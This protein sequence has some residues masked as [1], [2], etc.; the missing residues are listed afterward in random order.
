MVL[1]NAMQHQISPNYNGVSNA[2]AMGTTSSIGLRSAREALKLERTGTIMVETSNP[3][4][5]GDDTN[6]ASTIKKPDENIARMKIGRCLATV[7]VVA[8]TL[9]CVKDALVNVP[10]VAEQVV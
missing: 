6:V 7:N 1:Q 10:A 4:R 5:T 2:V 9:V 8:T 3:V